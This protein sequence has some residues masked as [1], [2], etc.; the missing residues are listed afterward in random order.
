MNVP[1]ILN[2]MVI[3]A[4]PILVRREEY[5]VSNIK[6]VNALILR[7][8]MVKSAF[9]LKLH[10]IMVKYGIRIYMHVHAQMDYI[11]WEINA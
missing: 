6:H 5:G 2:G 9:L 1:Q 11:M 10:A 8:G 7:Y 3:F 4:L